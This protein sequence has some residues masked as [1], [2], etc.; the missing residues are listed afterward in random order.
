MSLSLGIFDVSRTR[1]PAL[2]ISCIVS[3]V[4]AAAGNQVPAAILGA[5]GFAAATFSSLWQGRRLR[6]WAKMKTLEICYWIPGID[7]SV[8][9]GRTPP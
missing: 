8:Q 2:S 6:E 4:E 1:F 3:V 7:E 9:G 5:A